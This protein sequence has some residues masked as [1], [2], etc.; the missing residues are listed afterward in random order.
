MHNYVMGF[1][2]I[3]LRGFFRFMWF[4]ISIEQG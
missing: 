3:P 4:V 2:L 1:D